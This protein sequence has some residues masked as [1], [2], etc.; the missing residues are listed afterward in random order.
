MNFVGSARGQPRHAPRRMSATRA[1]RS[2]WAIPAWCLYDVANSTYAAVIVGTVFSTYYTK[3][4]VGNE[5]G[6]GDFWWGAVAIN[7]S[8]IIVAVTSPVMGAIADRS[9]ARRLLWVSYTAVAI[10][11]T[12]SLVLVHRGDVVLGCCLF[13]VA[14]VGVEGA[15]NFYNAYL[16]ELVAPERMGRISSWGFAAGYVGSL[17]GL[18]AALPLVQQ[19]RF[20]AVWLLIAGM[21]AILALPALLLVGPGGTKLMPIGLA[22]RHGWTHVGTIF[23]DVLKLREL[24]AF[25]LAYFLYINGVNAAVTFAGPYAQATFGLETPDVIKLFVMVQVAALVGALAMAKPTDVLGPKRVVQFSLVLWCATCL[26]LI[27][28]RDVRIF[29]GACVVAGIG[30]GSVQ[31]ASRT[32][33]ATLIPKGREDE[34][35]G[36]YALCGRSSTPL[37][38]AT[39]GLASVLSGSQRVAVFAITPFFLLGLLLVSR[40]KGGGPTA[41]A[42]PGDSASR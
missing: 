30:L 13:I 39:W 14:N 7:V 19:G 20:D 26:V 11:G 23:R 36:F 10:G 15:T 42:V 1:G 25:L 16:P 41:D 40:V 24:K 34:M 3:V 4:V 2:R 5:D 21:F 38:A 9:G 29:W 28:V 22:A 31:A 37:G 27:F 6:R 32:F 17:L 33:M 18:F 35:F 12:A 8:A